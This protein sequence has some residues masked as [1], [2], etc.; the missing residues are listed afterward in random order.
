MRFLAVAW[1]LSMTGS[2]CCFL[3]EASKE[4]DDAPGIAPCDCIVEE[5][6]SDLA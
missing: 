6:L 4:R 3:Q 1:R 2:G 5:L